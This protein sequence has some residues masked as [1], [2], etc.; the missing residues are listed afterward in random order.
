MFWEKGHGVDTNGYFFAIFVWIKYPKSPRGDLIYQYTNGP[1]AYPIS[2]FFH[3]F[4]V[5]LYSHL[6]TETLACRSPCNET[7]KN[8]FFHCNDKNAQIAWPKVEPS[9]CSDGRLFLAF[10]QRSTARNQF[11]Q[12][13]IEALDY[14]TEYSESREVIAKK[15]PL[16]KSDQSINQSIVQWPTERDQSINQGFNSTL[17]PCEIH[18]QLTYQMK[19][20]QWLQKVGCLKNRAINLCPLTTW[21]FFCRN[22]PRR[23]SWPSATSRGSPFRWLWA[24]P[25]LL[26]LSRR[27]STDIFSLSTESS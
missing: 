3:F 12:R 9:F 24:L 11:T 20:L 4:I 16:R 23:P 6:G 26:L 10:S 8:A 17:R 15:P 21:T 5:V 19:S 7:E 14:C 1:K 27:D 13:L 25:L 2:F 22:A 18:N